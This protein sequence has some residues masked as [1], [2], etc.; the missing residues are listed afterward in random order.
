VDLA[1]FKIEARHRR[2]ATH[3]LAL[4]DRVVASLPRW[5]AWA[6]R[7]PGLFNLRDR[8]PGAAR[9]TE[10]VLGID[11]RRSLPRWRSDTFLRTAAADEADP[12]VVLFADTFTQALE[13]ENAHDALRV[14]RAAGYRVAVARAP[15]GEA[16]LCCGR[17]W[18]T[19]GSL[20][21]AR[22]QAQRLLD[23]LAPHVARGAAIVGLEPSCLLSLRDEFLVMGLGERA[24]TVAQ[25]AFLVEEFLEVER[26]SGR[27][28]LLLRALPQSRAL[29]H[30]HCHQKAFDALT[31][32]RSMLQQIPGLTVDVVDSSCCGMAGGFGYE[33]EHYDASLAMAE[34]ALLPA[35]RAASHETLIV[36]G[37]TSC[38]HQIADGTRGSQPRTALHP[39]RV[40]AAALQ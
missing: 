39:I 24:A 12:D 32:V 14:L 37:G 5:A 15:A 31:P 7:M 17:T 35:V 40:L 3:G 19:A 36:A 22:R 33:A 2:Q 25:R 21:M 27:L 18:L 10:R 9:L 34:V 1:K 6:A 13:P 29:L 8:V 28:T 30:G 23:A 20:D 16:P 26:R 11:A 4:R 38:R